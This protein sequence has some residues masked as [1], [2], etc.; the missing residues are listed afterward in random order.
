M[1]LAKIHRVIKDG[2]VY[3]PDELMRSIAAR[4]ELEAAAIAK[5]Q[6]IWLPRR[7]GS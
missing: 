3:V 7:S 2:K 1:N 6:Y 5:D 4:A